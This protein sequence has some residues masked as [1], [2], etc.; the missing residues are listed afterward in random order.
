M[1]NLR[2]LQRSA[3]NQPMAKYF[4][5]PDDDWGQAANE[6]V[7]RENCYVCRECLGHIV[8]VDRDPGVTPMFLGC[9]ATEGCSG[10]MVSS[11]YPDPDKKPASIGP[12]TWEWFRPT[13]LKGYEPDMVDHISRGGLE[14][15]KIT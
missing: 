5:V 8:T 10:Q 7:G 15:R 13:D 6:R 2:R 11:G 14:L 9:R 1:G 3:R 12:A 4:M